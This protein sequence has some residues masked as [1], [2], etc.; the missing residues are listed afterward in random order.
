MYPADITGVAG[1]ALGIIAIVLVA[2]LLTFGLGITVYI[3]YS[4]GIYTIAQRRGIKHPWMAWL[5]VANMWVL[6]SIADQY[7]YVSH[8]QRIRF[9]R[10]CR[11]HRRRAAGS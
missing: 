11:P 9:L 6:G 3:L 7:R 2:Y 8:G 1:A 5:P 4:L 10:Q